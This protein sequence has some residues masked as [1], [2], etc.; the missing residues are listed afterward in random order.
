MPQIQLPT[1]T[2]AIFGDEEQGQLVITSV[3]N[4]GNLSGTAFGTP[5]MGIFDANSGLIHFS[6]KI[7]S[8]G[9]DTQSYTG[10]ISIVSTGVDAPSYLLAGS[11]IQLPFGLR[12]RFGW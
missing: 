8:T 10:Y 2:W 1:G 3:D 11:Y 6:R 12:A 4:H 7:G 9:I 5:I